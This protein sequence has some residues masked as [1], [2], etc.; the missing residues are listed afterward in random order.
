MPIY[1]GSFESEEVTM[2][3]QAFEDTL[4]TLGL[5]DR[6]DPMTEMVRRRWLSWRQGAC[7]TL[8]A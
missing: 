2:L 6:K 4:D 7:V 3:G 8:S 1:Q 5:V